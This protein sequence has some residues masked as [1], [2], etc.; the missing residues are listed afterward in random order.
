M[1]TS[2][3]TAW[4]NGQ[5]IHL[6][7]AL[8]RYFAG[9][10]HASA[11]LQAAHASSVAKLRVHTNQPGSLLPRGTVLAQFLRSAWMAR[12]ICRLPIRD[13]ISA[14]RTTNASPLLIQSTSD[15]IEKY[16][17]VYQYMRNMRFRRPACLEDSIC[18][19]IFL[20]RFIQGPSF[21]IG[22]VQ[23]PFMAHAWVQAGE[24][25]VND[26]KGVVEAYSEI[27]R[28]EL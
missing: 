9:T 24:I 12:K 26:T 15:E 10:L 3:P 22:V 14:M 25:L 23:P 7:L 6:D 1:E 20:R 17:W 5:W 16:A 13:Q 11:S 2:K 21:H 19:A 8:N 28:L 4:S 27:L 18:C